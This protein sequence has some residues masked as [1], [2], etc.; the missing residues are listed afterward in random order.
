MSFTYTY[1][2]TGLD[3]QGNNITGVR[4]ELTGTDSNGEFGVFK[5]STP[6]D[7]TNQN[8]ESLSQDTVI[9]WVTDVIANNKTYAQHID[10]ELQRQIDMKATNTLNVP[11]LKANT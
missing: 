4:W 7:K 3:I 1:K 9:S 2:I 11:W 8:V 5:G 10:I 6:V